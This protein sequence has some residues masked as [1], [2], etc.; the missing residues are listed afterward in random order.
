M[1]F[2]K[3]Q[4]IFFSDSNSFSLSSVNDAGERIEFSREKKIECPCDAEY[5]ND[6]PES[7]ECHLIFLQGRK[8]AMMQRLNHSAKS[9]KNFLGEYTGSSE[10]RK[11][12]SLRVMIASI[13]CAKAQLCCMA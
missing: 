4:R 10:L 6:C 5:Y 12:F 13:E 8:N 3:L 7:A 1:T 2:L 9:C 11:C